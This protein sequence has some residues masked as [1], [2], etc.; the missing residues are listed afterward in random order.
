MRICLAQTKPHK[1]DVDLNIEGHKK[2]ILT[3]IDKKSD[4]IVF[5]ELSLTGYEP[6]LSEKLA[7]EKT[8]PRLAQFQMMSDKGGISIVIGM[9]FKKNSGVCIAAAIFQPGVPVT[10]YCKR[11]LHASEEPYFVPGN[12]E[13]AVLSVAN[14]N[15]G[16]AICY[17]LSIDSHVSSVFSAGSDVYVASVVHDVDSVHRCDKKLSLIAKEYSKNVFCVNC[18]GVSGM[19]DS[20][21]NSAVWD[22]YGDLLHQMD[23]K[24]E[25]VL[26]FDINNQAIVQ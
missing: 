23:D 24:T 5:P 4:L 16:L 12:D 20:F 26:V 21:G 22:K 14:R 13:V 10:V 8:D 7:I 18:V 1:G 6:E 11:Y 2:F 9:P 3:A 17:E 25:G 15:V 19:Y